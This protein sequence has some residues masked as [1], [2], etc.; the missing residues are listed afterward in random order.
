MG[1]F[2]V[3]YKQFFKNFFVYILVFIFKTL[4]GFLKKLSNF[5][6]VFLIVKYYFLIVKG[7]GYKWI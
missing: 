3:M 2:I 6:I 1:Y 4:E 5:I 7:D